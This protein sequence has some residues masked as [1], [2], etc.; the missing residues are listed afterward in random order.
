MYFSLSV[1]FLSFPDI[2][3]K[4]SLFLSCF[5]F[6]FFLFFFVKKKQEF[7]FCSRP[8]LFSSFLHALFILLVCLRNKIGE[9]VR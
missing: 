5:F 8:F 4:L 9:V 3:L 6:L 1:F 2:F 7:I